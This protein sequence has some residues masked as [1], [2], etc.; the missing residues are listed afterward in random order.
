MK[1]HLVFFVKCCLLNSNLCACCLCGK[2]V[3][4]VHAVP[5]AR[6]RATDLF[7][8]LVN[9]DFYSSAMFVQPFTDLSHMALRKEKTGWNNPAR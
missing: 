2:G 6:G 4:G 9:D 3:E 7:R 5:E 8:S 1:N